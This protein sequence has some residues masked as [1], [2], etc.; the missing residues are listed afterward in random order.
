MQPKQP[1]IAGRFKSL[2]PLDEGS[3]GVIYLAMNKDQT[4]VALKRIRMRN[5]ENG[6]DFNTIMEIRQL[7]E[8]NHP[9]I[10]KFVGAYSYQGSLYIATEYMPTTLHSII[11][12]PD[13][14][15]G[16]LSPPDIKCIMHGVL[17]GM[18]YLHENYILHRDLK[19]ANIMI[20]PTGITKIIDFGYSTDYPGELGPMLHEAMTIW[21][22]PPELLFGCTNYGPA[23][24]MWS[25]GCV[26]AEMILK[27][28]FL[29]GNS[30]FNQL[31]LIANV[32]GNPVW[33]GCDS[34]PLFRE[35]T[36]QSQVRPL[37]D[38]F[39]AVTEDT[40]DLLAR[41]FEIDPSKRISASEALQHPYFTCDPQM[42]LPSKIKMPKI[43]TDIQSLTTQAGAVTSIFSSRPVYAPGTVRVMKQT[44][45]NQN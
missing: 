25:V 35:V 18:A 23:S 17:S 19:P 37:K 10:I 31:Q 5:P 9:N 41:L 12:N 27:H 21:Y 22:R 43:S 15:A 14:T 2:K 7:A 33:P 20:S 40:I 26:F 3:Y 38:Y 13:H 11:T 4:L 30:D 44:Q 42:T 16:Y 32:F 24:D 36:P 6:I 45:K 39:S 34:L 1:L 8:L 28:P 29:T